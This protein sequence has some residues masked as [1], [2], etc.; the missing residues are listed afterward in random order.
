MASVRPGTLPQE[1]CDAWLEALDNDEVTHHWASYKWVDINKVPS[2]AAASADTLLGQTVTLVRTRLAATLPGFSDGW[3]EVAGIET[4]INPRTAGRP[5]HFHW[6]CDEFRGRHHRGLACPWIS[7]VCY[8][9]SDGGPTVV[10]EQ[11]PNEKWGRE[12]SHTACWPLAGS[13]MALE[14]DCL[15][16]VIPEPGKSE[17]GMPSRFTLVLNLWK[18]RPLNAMPVLP[19]FDPPPVDHSGAAA[20]RAPVVLTLTEESASKEGAPP[21]SGDVAPESETKQAD[22]AEFRAMLGM[23]NGRGV[24]VLRLPPLYWKSWTARH[25]A[26]QIRFTQPVL[27]TD[28]EQLGRKSAATPDQRVGAEQLDSLSADRSGARANPVKPTLAPEGVLPL[29]FDESMSMTILEDDAGTQQRPEAIR[30]KIVGIYFSAAWCKPCHRFSPVLS[31]LRA[32]HEEDFVVV[33]VSNDRSE[34][35]MKRFSDGKGFL[36]VPFTSRRRQWL[37]HRLAV[38]MVP[39]LV[40]V[41]GSTGEVLTSWGRAAVLRNPEGCV[42]SWK[43]GGNGC[44]WSKMVTGTDW[45]EESAASCGVGGACLVQ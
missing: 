1:V 5:L 21:P 23:F 34:A 44:S 9:A 45:G 15:H 20:A 41:D 4:W 11:R 17:K 27:I 37:H 30:G 8:L 35:E 6:D 28:R 22:F 29:L 39:T 32:A 14:G 19:E 40:I 7:V 12:V 2:S 18:E 38:N 13:V 3:P 25:G 43:A 10:I 31:K 16:G 36:R 26:D 33:F 24:L 42:E